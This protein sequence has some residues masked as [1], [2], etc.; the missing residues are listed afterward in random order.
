MGLLGT[1]PLP[2]YGCHGV[3]V[4]HKAVN[5]RKRRESDATGLVDVVGAM[6]VTEQ[7]DEPGDE[8][9][10]LVRV[11]D[12]IHRDVARGLGRR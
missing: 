3:E 8:L 7:A 9:A 5:S 4:G 1:L 10:A 6:R 2:L 12:G 11:L